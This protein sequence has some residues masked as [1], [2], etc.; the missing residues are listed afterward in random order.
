MLYLSTTAYMISILR[1]CLRT[2]IILLLFTF[3][4]AGAYGTFVLVYK[5]VDM[6]SSIRDFFL[7]GCHFAVFEEGATSKVMFVH[8]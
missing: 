5:I 3:V 6:S 2:Y 8:F 4:F 1:L 7:N